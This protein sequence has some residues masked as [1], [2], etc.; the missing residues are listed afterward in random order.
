M[1]VLG[2]FGVMLGLV[3]ALP[4][5]VDLSGRVVPTSA[6]TCGLGWFVVAASIVLAV[7]AGVTPVVG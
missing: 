1:A 5:E 4:P 7:V 2:L 3:L 6:P